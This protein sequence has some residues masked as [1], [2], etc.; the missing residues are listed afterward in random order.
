MECQI[1]NSL[2]VG[3]ITSVVGTIIMIITNKDKKI[4]IAKHLIIFFIVGILVHLIL[5]YF[6]FNTLCYEKKCIGDQCRIELCKK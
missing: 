2:L 5:E 6:N 1:K 4:N 3:I